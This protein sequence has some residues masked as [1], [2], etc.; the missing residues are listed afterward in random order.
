[1]PGVAR[2]ILETKFEFCVE[3]NRILKKKILLA[4]VT[5]VARKGF[6][7]KI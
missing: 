5:N 6:L 2:G 7:K 1:M 4:Y 3:N